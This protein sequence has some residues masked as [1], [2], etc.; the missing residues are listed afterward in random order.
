MGASPMSD[1]PIQYDFARPLAEM[2]SIPTEQA[3]AGLIGAQT[4]GAQIANQEAA[5][6]LKLFQ[7]AS[8]AY[9]DGGATPDSNSQQGTGTGNPAIG[10]TGLGSDDVSQHAFQQYAPTPTAP[11]PSVMRQA[12]AFAM[13]GHPQ[14]GAAIKAQ[15]DASVAGINQNKQKAANEA[16]VNAQTIF[17]A[18]PGSSFAVL[19]QLNPTAAAAIKAK[20]PNASAAQLDQDARQMSAHVGAATHQYTDRPTTMANGVLI[21]QKDG[22][23]VLGTDQVLTGLTSEDKQKA[24][25]AANELVT[26]PRSDGSTIQVPRWQLIGAHSPEGYV[27]AADHAARVAANN[28]TPGAAASVNHLVTPGTAPPPMGMA[29][30]GVIKAGVPGS[31]NLLAGITSPAA[32]QTPAPV[33]GP[34]PTADATLQA[35]LN[36][37]AYK[38]NVPPVTRGTSQTPAA[39]KVAGAIADSQTTLLNDQADNSKIAGRSLSYS[40]LAM[41]ILNG[42]GVNTGW[43]SSQITTMK[44]AL[45]QVGVPASLLGNL[46]S[47][48]VELNKYLTQAALQ[49]LKATYGARVSQMEVFLNLQKANPSAEMPMQAIKVLLGNSIASSQYDVDSAK[50]ANSYVKAGNDPRLFDTWNQ[51]KY[52]RENY[53]S[54]PKA[55]PSNAPAQAADSG[56]FI[57]GKTYRDKNGATSI[58]GGNGKWQ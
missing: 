48:N 17:T 19:S 22:E 18:P 10:S 32:G 45:Q 23:P 5:L 43:G 39:A 16:Y 53:T 58:Y 41:G 46:A 35:K 31:N 20:F 34:A 21:D 51:D 12:T 1:G 50:R 2:A 36:D 6:S 9:Q 29:D 57:P 7:N 52:P 15:W 3:Q 38:L 33:A 54:V 25:G 27:V 26:V 40:K 44:M 4:Q 13:S 56:G 28:A 49:Q 24:Y 14:A 42:G 8:A 55:A 30:S 47:N 37:P 11:P